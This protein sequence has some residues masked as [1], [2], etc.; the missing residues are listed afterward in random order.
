MSRI[1]F[2]IIIHFHNILNMFNEALI[3]YQFNREK[4]STEITKIIRHVTSHHNLINHDI[5]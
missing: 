2:L 1:Q 3:E 4:Q 5:L